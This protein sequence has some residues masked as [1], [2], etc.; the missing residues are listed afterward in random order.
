MEYRREAKRMGWIPI[1]EKY[2]PQGL[3]V[4]LEVSGTFSASYGLVADHSFFIGAWIVPQGEDKGSWLLWDNS[5]NDCG[6]DDGHIIYPKVH[7]WMPLPKHYAQP[8]MGF[9]P[10]PDMMEHAMFEDDPEY[11][12]KGDCVYEQMSLDEW[13][14][15]IQH[16]NY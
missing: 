5:N 1:E 6:P 14:G 8:E 2:P 16:D 13:I 7:A 11:L 9:E 3:N 4:L 12:Y 15:V 10:E